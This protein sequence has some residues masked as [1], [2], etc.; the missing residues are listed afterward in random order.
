MSQ[1][2]E[3][4]GFGQSLGPWKYSGRMMK[5]GVVYISATQALSAFRKCQVGLMKTLSC[6]PKRR[7]K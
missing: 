7:A 2:G 3:V 1:S 5:I 4:G 6:S